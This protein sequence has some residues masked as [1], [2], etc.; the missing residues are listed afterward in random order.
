MYGLSDVPIDGLD[1]AYALHCSTLAV[2]PSTHFSAKARLTDAS[3]RIDSSRLRAMTGSMTL[4]SKLP[5]APPKATAASLPT[6]CDTT[7]H[8]ASGSTGFTL[9]G[10]IDDPGCRSGMK[11]SRR[12]VRGPEPI[13]RMSL[14]HLY[15]D[16]AI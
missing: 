8:T 7:W 16:T 9:P 13:H 14:A 6:T 15:S 3:S 10:M 12:P 5:A 4:S 2:M 1:S 11:I